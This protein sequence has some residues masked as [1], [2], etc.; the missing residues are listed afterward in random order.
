MFNSLLPWIAL[1]LASVTAAAE[2]GPWS[3]GPVLTLPV[4]AQRLAECNAEI[5]VARRAVDAS[6]GDQRS[7]SHV[8]NPLLSVSVSNINPAVGTGEGLPWH[9]TVDSAVRLDQLFERGGKRAAREQVA[10]ANT[11]ASRAAQADTELRTEQALLESY[12]AVSVQ[13]RAVAVL[14]QA[15]ASYREALTAMEKRQAAG[16]I[17]R[18]EVSRAALD[19]GRAEAD[20]ETAQQELTVARTALA[21]LLGVG[22][23]DTTSSVGDLEEL[24]ASA[25]TNPP[26]PAEGVIEQ[27]ADVRAAQAALES[28]MAG[29]RVARAARVRD[30]DLTVGF[31]HWPTSTTNLQGTGDSYSLGVSVPLFL[32]D[33]GRG[34]LA[35]ALADRSSATARR[36]QALERA[37]GEVRGARE[38]YA[39]ATDLE[40]RYRDQLL[41]ASQSIATALEAAYRRGGVSLLDLLDARR[42]A[43]QVEQS[44]LSSVRD[45][46]VALGRL[47]LSEG[48][49]PLA[50]FGIASVSNG[51]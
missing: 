32:Y 2:C 51:P 14:D 17:A 12:V 44:A 46:L 10:L 25:L 11:R 6:L 23:L 21:L 40:K 37:E 43:R 38:A 31:D 36:Q 48:L 22:V 7:V 3:V 29:V 26:A 9:R 45:R 4:A 42:N 33:S 16:D 41:P 35:H 34:Q 19:L 39:H 28:T 1:A 30:V 20:E 49:S 50:A 5:A 13:H 24:S 27:R 47:N 8:P 15:V 18:V